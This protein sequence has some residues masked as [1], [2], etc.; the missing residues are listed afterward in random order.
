MKPVRHKAGTG[1]KYGLLN[2]TAD[3]FAFSYFSNSIMSRLSR[4]I[5]VRE[6]SFMPLLLKSAPPGL[7]VFSTATATPASLAPDWRTISISPAVSFPPARKS[8]TISTVSSDEMQ[9]FETTRSYTVPAVY[10]AIFADQQSPL[11]ASRLFLRAKT[12]LVLN[13]SAVKPVSYTHLTLPTKA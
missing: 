12:A 3:A 8:S 10:D 1:L 7:K 2:K 11:R 6:T 5:L 13:F 9:S 4:E